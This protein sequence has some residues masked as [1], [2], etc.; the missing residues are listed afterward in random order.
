M[1]RISA[2]RC[3]VVPPKVRRQVET[4][5]VA[6]LRVANMLNALQA[7]GVLL[8][9]VLLPLWRFDQGYDSFTT[10]KFALW[11]GSVAVLV[12]LVLVGAVRGGA[13]AARQGRGS[14][15]WV[16]LHPVTVA[17]L[18]CVGWAEITTTW[19]A[20]GLL[21][22][23]AIGPWWTA[24]FTL[25]LIQH[26]FLALGSREWKPGYSRHN[27][28]FLRWLAWGLVGAG[29]VVALWVLYEDWCVAFAPERLGIVSKLEDWRG[30][31]V[32]SLGNTSHIGD[33]C[34][35][36]FLLALLGFV[37][38][39]RWLV[40]LLFGAALAV[41][42]AALIVSFSFHSNVS[43]IVGVLVLLAGQRR[44]RFGLVRRRWAGED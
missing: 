14:A 28:L 34:S 4:G 19:A 1:S 9:V 10:P 33:F 11:S 26:V 35:L 5:A 38:A 42:A 24:L 25:L 23:R 7:A 40:V 29:A 32:A 44:N 22:R 27:W 41:L 8:V 3:E 20:S 12:G 17:S 15:I 30:Y 16:L 31:L 18:A 13:D 2:K 6:R 37:Y 21:A 43:L 39:R 36:A